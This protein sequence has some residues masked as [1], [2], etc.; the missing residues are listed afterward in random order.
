VLE[1]ELSQLSTS[2]GSFIGDHTA[3]LQRASR[4]RHQL[5]AYYSQPRFL[6]LKWKVFRKTQ[7]SDAKLTN[8]FK[9]K[10]GNN[11]VA[12][13]GNWNGGQTRRYQVS[14]KG[15]G[16][17]RTFRKAGIS[18]LLVSECNTSKKCY[19]CKQVETGKC[20]IRN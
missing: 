1:T 9:A 6:N 12:L 17:R 10:Y 4:V 20:I 13:F 11:A 19:D 16:M 15:V 2:T 5:Y 18:V 3:Y 14:T 8:A 7:R